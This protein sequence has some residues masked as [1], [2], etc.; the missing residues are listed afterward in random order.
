[1]LVLS[2][3]LYRLIDSKNTKKKSFEINECAELDT[4]LHAEQN[5]EDDEVNKIIKSEEAK[6]SLFCIMET[7]AFMFK[8][9]ILK[10]EKWLLFT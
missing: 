8:V 6:V 1:M 4:R 2:N 10:E 7:H 5:N 3:T 9:Y